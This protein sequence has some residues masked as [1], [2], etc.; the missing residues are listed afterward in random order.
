MINELE[1]AL[2]EYMCMII[3]ATLI[4]IGFEAKKRRVC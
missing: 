4:C 1:N 2:I 3:V